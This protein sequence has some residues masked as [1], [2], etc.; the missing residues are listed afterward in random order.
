[1]ILM[2]SLYLTWTSEHTKH[3][4]THT[5]TEDVL[6]CHKIVVECRCVHCTCTSMYTAAKYLQEIKFFG[7]SCIE[8]DLCMYAP[9]FYLEPCSTSLYPFMETSSST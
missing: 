8:K 6:L 5:V 9:T 2:F 1:M 7:A 4:F 3:F